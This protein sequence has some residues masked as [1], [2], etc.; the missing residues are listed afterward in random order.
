VG[1]KKF[2]PTTNGRRNMTGNSFEEITT[3]TPHKKLTMKLK[4]HA[5]R[6]SD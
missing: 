6:G 3:S 2:K 1:I 4:R 5:G